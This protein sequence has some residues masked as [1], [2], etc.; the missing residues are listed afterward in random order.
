MQSKTR[1]ITS[2]RSM[3]S[4]NEVEFYRIFGNKSFRHKRHYSFSLY[5][6]TSIANT[7]R[8]IDR[9]PFAS[10]A[11][12]SRS[13]AT[14]ARACHYYASGVSPVVSR[15]SRSYTRQNNQPDN[16]EKRDERLLRG[17]SGWWTVWEGVG[18]LLP[19]ALHIGLDK[20]IVVTS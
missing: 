10:C 7:S 3:R 15:L 6:N 2:S 19:S 4:R 13:T 12:N 17:C 5:K 14:N 20:L 16:A 11:Y 8:P 1:K 9:P 18:L